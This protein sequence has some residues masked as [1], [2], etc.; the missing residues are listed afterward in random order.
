VKLLFDFLLDTAN[1]QTDY[2]LYAG[3][4]LGITVH[5][6]WIWNINDRFVHF[7]YTNSDMHL[8]GTGPL[9][10]MEIQMHCNTLL[11]WIIKYIRRKESPDD[12]PDH[13]IST[14]LSS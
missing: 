12:E 13:F 7:I 5:F 4:F 3:I 8:E 10:Q 11:F 6:F 9:L 14:T 2:T 1:L